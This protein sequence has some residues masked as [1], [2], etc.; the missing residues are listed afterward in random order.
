MTNLYTGLKMYRF[1]DGS[2]KPE[3]IR[4]K[5]VNQDKKQIS[6]FDAEN[7]VRKMSFKDTKSYKTLAP[8]GLLIVANVSINNDDDVVILLN[9]F[10]KSDV[11]MKT[12]KGESYAICRQLALDPFSMMSEPDSIIYGISI[13]VD[14]CP[15]NIHYGWYFAYDDIGYKKNIAVYL[16]DTT[17]SILSLID[18]N[19]FDAVLDGLYKKYSS[20]Y[21]GFCKSLKEL[22]NTNSFMFDFRRCFNIIEVP[23]HID[24]SVDFL[25]DENT[26]Y[27][28]SISGDTIVET[29]MMKYS[30]EINTNEF[31]REYMLIT[32]AAD[33]HDKVF[34]VG[35]DKV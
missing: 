4:I 35:Y 14:T 13:S 12:G 2:D 33:N 24:E 30:K 26:A 6:Y 19:K 17:D 22:I 3:I 15:A 21:K 32:S 11:M 20:Q 10:P 27:L 16:D 8:D 23:F 28:S 25:S 9:Q 29:Y 31:A 18:T 7:K 34:I 1:K 5:D